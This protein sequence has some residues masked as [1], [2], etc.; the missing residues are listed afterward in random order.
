MIPEI[1]INRVS[2]LCDACQEGGAAGDAD[3]D[4]D[5]E[6]SLVM[7]NV[8]GSAGQSA[9][10][11]APGEL[12]W[13]AVYARLDKL[14]GMVEALREDNIRL[15]AELALTQALRSDIKALEYR[16]DAITFWGMTPGRPSGTVAPGPSVGLSQVLNGSGNVTCGP[17]KTSSPVFP[18]YRDINFSAF[19]TVTPRRTEI[20]PSVENSAVLDFTG[21][22]LAP[23]SSKL[24]CGLSQALNLAPLPKVRV[25]LESITEVPNA[26]DGTPSEHLK[27]IDSADEPIPIADVSV[28]GRGGIQDERERDSKAKRQ[29]S[30]SARRVENKKRPLIVG[31]SCSCP[32][33]A[34]PS[35][36]RLGS[37]SAQLFV[38]RLAL[39]VTPERIKDYLSS[40][41]Y[42]SSVFQLQPPRSVRTVV[43]NSFR[44]TVPRESMGNLLKPEI[45]PPGAGVKQWFFRK[46]ATT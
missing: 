44:V 3:A 22:K 37:D 7:E 1:L 41:G 6:R 2:W 17:S 39:D 26:G 34:V 13:G 38:T 21:K 43:Y 33:T 18:R 19:G 24:S 12:S 32:L 29:A 5:N 11:G 15:R 40:L 35:S 8:S 25:P 14:E 23:S 45:W 36:E 42:S 20:A 4:A 30:K 9:A 46:P 28:D 27:A 10:D 16:I 31:T